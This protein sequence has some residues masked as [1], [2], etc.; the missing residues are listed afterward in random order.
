MD[1]VKQWIGKLSVYA[2]K[3]APEQQ[4]SLTII[5]ICLETMR[6]FPASLNIK[7]SRVFA[8]TL[9][10]CKWLGSVTNNIMIIFMMDQPIKST[11]MLP[12]DSMYVGHMVMLVNKYEL[13]V[14]SGHIFLHLGKK[15]ISNLFV[16]NIRTSSRQPFNTKIK[17]C[18]TRRYNFAQYRPV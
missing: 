8:L 4:K 17:I 16:S 2:A 3:N 1:I 15:N 14:V 12:T 13:S 11:D 10:F 9:S 18:F 7:D 5:L 6:H